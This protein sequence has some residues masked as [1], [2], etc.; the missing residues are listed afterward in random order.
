VFTFQDSN[1]LEFIIK[2]VEAL[3]PFHCDS[4]I[5]LYRELDEVNEITFI[6]KGEYKIGYEINKTQRFR[7][8][9][10]K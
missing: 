8:L 6:E 9:F 7:L 5:V 4:N 1:Y 2:V 10:S 3:K